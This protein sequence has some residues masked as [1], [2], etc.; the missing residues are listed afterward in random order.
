MSAP[1]APHQQT[2]PDPYAIA[3]AGIGVLL[4]ALVLEAFDQVIFLAPFAASATVIYALPDSPLAQPR[5][6]VGG[7]LIGVAVGLTL[8]AVFVSVA[9][10]P[11][12]AAALAVLLMAATRTLHPPA[13]ATAILAYQHSGQPVDTLTAVAVAAIVT[14]TCAVVLIRL[15]HRRAYPAP[16]WAGERLARPVAQENS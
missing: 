1:P 6:I 12:I 7:N 5:S 10:G 15:A 2:H 4:T 9:V 11:A 3:I 13:V 16:G 14:V 8:G